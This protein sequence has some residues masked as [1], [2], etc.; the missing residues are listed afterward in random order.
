MYWSYPREDPVV[1][2]TIL[3]G[4]AMA[5]RASEEGAIRENISKM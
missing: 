2:T 4:D 5:K 3:Q 1:D